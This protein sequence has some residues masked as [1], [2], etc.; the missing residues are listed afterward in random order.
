[1]SWPVIRLPADS[2]RYVEKNIISVYSSIREIDQF[3]AVVNLRIVKEDL[4][5]RRRVPDFALIILLFAL[6][7]ILFWQQ[8]LGGRTLIPTEN[9]YQFE[10]YATYREVVSAPSVPHNALVSDLVLQNY[11]WK[12]FIRESIAKGEIPLW[13]PHQ[14]SG[15]P[16]L[17][18]GQQSTLYPFSILYY[19]LPLPTAYGW[20]T[21]V[22]LWL[23]GTFMFLFLR[24]VGLRR[25][26]ALLAGAVYQ[27]SGFFV[28]SAV[29]PMIIASAAWLPLILLAVE[30]II[31][32][33]PALR[34]RGSTVPWLVVGSVALGCNVL[35][36]HIEITYYVLIITAYY[37]L[38]RLLWEWWRNR[39]LKWLLG[40]GLWLA[41]MMALGLGLGAIQIVPLFEFASINYRDGR[42][43][44]DQVLGWA[45]PPRD[46][47]QFLMPN[48]YGNPSHHSFFDVF[49]GQTV[50]QF[51]NAHGQPI[52]TIDWGI[53]NYVEGALYLGI[54]PLLLAFYGLLY[55]T[56]SHDSDKKPPLRAIFAGLTAISLTFMFGLPTYALLY[57]GFP[58]I[59]QL[60]SPFRWIFAV[61]LGVAVLAGFGADVLFR[62]FAGLNSEERVGRVTQLFMAG[63]LVAGAGL[64]TFLLISRQFFASFE[65]L[66]QRI[67]DSM[68]LAENA[69]SD[70]RMFFSYQ[71]A[72]FGMLGLLLLGVGFVF[73]LARRGIR[74]RTIPL[75]HLLAFALVAF[76]LI[77][78]SWS[79]NPASD[80][81]LLEFTPPA[82]LWL[83]Q[84]PGQWR[85][86]TVDDPSLGER[87]KIMNA[88]MGWRYGLDDIRGY[89]SIVPRQYVDFMTQIAPQVQLDFN[90]VAPLYTDEQYQAMSKDFR[91][92]DALESPLLALLNVRYI[93]TS[94]SMNLNDYLPA[95]HDVRTGAILLPTQPVYEDEAVRIWERNPFP[96]AYVAVPTEGG[97]PTLDF[98]WSTGFDVAI[99]GDTGREK[100]LHANITPQLP[101]SWLVV[102]ETYLPGW[103]AFVRPRGGDDHTEQPLDVQKVM[104]NFIGMNVSP[105]ITQKLFADLHDNLPAAQRVALDNGQLTVRLVYS[106]PSFQ[107]GLFGSFISAVL[108]V[109]A[110]GIYVW[111]L[112]IIG[113]GQS[114]GV[115]VIARNSLAP[116]ILNLFN[117]GIDF[118]F[119]FVMLRILGPEGNGIYTYAAFVFIW[120]DI[121]TNFGLNV[122]LTREVARDHNK[123]W[124]YFFNTSVL[125]FLLIVV[126]V[127]LLVIFLSL[128]K[129]ASG[130]QPLTHEAVVAII[131]LYIGLLPNSLSA[132]MSALFYAFQKAEYP[133]AI[134]TVSTICKALFGLV[135]LI[136][137]MGVIGLAGVSILT[138]TITLAIMLWVGKELFGPATA[139]KNGRTLQPDRSLIRGMVGEGWPLMLNH[140]LA[141]IFFQIDV[142]II[143]YF[144]GDTMLG[145]YGVAYKWISALNVIPA[146]FTM[147]LLPLMSKQAHEDRAALKRNYGLAIKLLIGTA[148]PIA[149]LFTFLAYA[150]TGL[151]GGREFLPDGAIATQLMIWSIPIGWINS[152]T[153]YVLIALDLQRRITRAFVVA[154]GFNIISNL[155]LIPPYGYRAAA[156]TTIASELMLLIP[157]ALLL[158]APL[159]NINW[160][161]LL[162]KPL[163][164]AAVM[165][166]ILLVGWNILPVLA[167]MVAV[168]IYVVVLVALR[169]LNADELERLMPLIPSKVRGVIF[170]NSVA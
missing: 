54:L 22:Q 45:H 41:V 151:L 144:H 29:F 15:I 158:R 61:T 150:L 52:T 156:L 170:R 130:T 85:Y 159:G 86:T 14:F 7:L 126:G 132:G 21:V 146:F 127:I 105:A 81:A 124:S 19:I 90:R 115:Q 60:H 135:V 18:A 77:T 79:F 157:F 20:F 94:R 43:S 166:A 83:K 103:R 110:G 53:K 51:T 102:S 106:P 74:I 78:A 93:I 12:S 70:A 1:M 91:L 76:D 75:W 149:V 99:E 125:R 141:T 139:G 118:G 168:V 107:V 84:Q 137:D 116:I 31:Q 98:Q 131:L 37:A 6:P 34:G 44:L 30:F 10:P 120:F 104:D 165:L 23:A 69:F 57:Y 48:F 161:R 11:Q 58:G 109:F 39:S 113:D 36:G 26:G 55:R 62:K 89:E 92:R 9:L 27:L 101:A 114:S 80:A 108:L 155:L 64:L 112:F 129:S 96:R 88:N 121:F 153:Q 97:E 160:V 46:L 47:I 136:S 152:L 40:R 68:A 4:L 17:A 117:R 143:Q 167:L 140:F 111:R 65:P 49:T 2:K 32:Q 95:P 63:S 122:F 145:Q 133:A 28:I 162:W 50:T 13:N 82:I 169:P 123:S 66:F 3:R 8:T 67:V 16:F 72:N 138:N 38:V 100:I 142:V 71:F 148:L 25:F 5:L 33:R 147:A 59:N 134:S 119:A 128:R 164:A 56:D 73:W 87:G 154:V 42:A 24:G 35:A 163:A